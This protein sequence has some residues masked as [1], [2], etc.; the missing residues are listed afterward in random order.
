MINYAYAYAEIDNITGMCLGVV[1]TS[2]ADFAGPTAGG[3]TYISIPEYSEEYLFKYY[4]FDAEK[5]YYD[6]EMTQEF[7]L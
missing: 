5:W 2:D 6:A 7:I 3:T 4:S 1:D